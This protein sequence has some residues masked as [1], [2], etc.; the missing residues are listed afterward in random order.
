MKTKILLLIMLMPV[1]LTGVG[2]YE[3]QN[4]FNL[5]GVRFSIDPRM[6]IQ[7]AT[8]VYSYLDFGYNATV[9]ADSVTLIYSHPAVDI[10]L[11]IGS[12]DELGNGCLR[13]T[14]TTDY[15]SELNVHDL[16]LELN[17]SG[18]SAVSALR[19]RAAI[20]SR[21]PEDNISLYPYTD[22][23]MEYYSGDAAFWVV[24]SN[25]SGCKDIEMLSDGAVH[26]YDHTLHFARH[27][28][29]E[30]SM[31][32]VLTDTMK[33]FAGDS[34]SYGFLMF[35]Q[36]PPLLGIN[37]WL[38]DKKAAFVITNDADQ[39]AVPRLQAVYFGSSNSNSPKY[40]TAGIVANHIKMSNTVFGMNYQVFD[41]LWQ[42]MRNNGISIG[43]HTYSPSADTI[44]TMA[45]NLLNT[46]QDYNIR[47]WIDHGWDSNPEDFCV[48]GV[49]PASPQYI[50]DVINQ[51]N[52]DYVWLGDNPNSN[53]L[54]SFTEPWR[55]P[56]RLYGFPELTR[57][58][59]FF[60]RT[61]M[62]GW[63]Y[64]NYNYMADMIHNL[65]AENLDK[66]INERGLS[67]AY[68]HF[69][70][71]ASAAI[72][73]FFNI[74]PNGDYEV[75]DEVNERLR[76][77]DYYQTER[78]LWID[79]LENVFD[80]ML[81]IEQVQITQVQ[82]V[83]DTGDYLI[84]LENDSNYDLSELYVLTT[85]ADTLPIGTPEGEM[86]AFLPAH[87][88][89]TLSTSDHQH[90]TPSPLDYYAVYENH[91]IYLKS[92]SDSGIVPLQIKV[93][94]IKGQLVQS[95]STHE[96]QSS[97]EIP[98]AGKAAGVYIIKLALKSGFSKALRVIV[99]NH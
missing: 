82:Q 76:M 3:S 50:L 37:R 32:S 30:T 89:I 73:A 1:L 65:T 63:E 68:T 15:H 49:D 83:I 61:K 58:V 48:N 14:V 81:A 26:L 31:F 57:P 55:L 66:L 75:K 71:N 99:L 40:L 97:V 98:F 77:L 36:K 96:N 29:H 94:N 62:E 43:Y 87:S 90:V 22:K 72:S 51:S 38:A 95:T 33:R 56:H 27:Y 34:D 69:G 93:C 16:L 8:N 46:M 70:F 5:N 59:Y 67:V 88:A 10:T 24:G 92:K 80:R 79:T 42:S 84:T 21:N 86:V 45:D 28:V 17:F 64:Y 23:A 53:P 39:E 60:G 7:T 35:S 44:Q 47:M 85:Q 25:Y 12:A 20:Q 19:G 91:C 74:L 6:K 11:R 41:P 54:N 18:T 4:T 9:Y 78:G 52:I 2:W 13:A